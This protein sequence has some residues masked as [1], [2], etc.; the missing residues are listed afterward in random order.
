MGGTL[1]AQAGARPAFGAGTEPT[2]IGGLRL[3]RTGWRDRVRLIGTVVAGAVSGIAVGWLLVELLI[4][5]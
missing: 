5:R 1:L 3:P 4:F 2:Q